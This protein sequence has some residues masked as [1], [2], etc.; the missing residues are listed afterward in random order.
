MKSKEA[1]NGHIQLI[2]GVFAFLDTALTDDKIEEA[3][4]IDPED[5]S[6]RYWLLSPRR[7]IADLINETFRLQWKRCPL[8]KELAEYRLYYRDDMA[9][10]LAVAYSMKLRGEDPEVALNADYDVK[11]VILSWQDLNEL[12][13]DYEGVWREFR[14]LQEEGD[15]VVYYN[16][17]NDT[18]YY[19]VRG[20]RIVWKCE[21]MQFCNRSG[22]GKYR[23]AVAEFNRR[24]GARGFLNDEFV[25]PDPDWVNP[26]EPDPEP[27][28]P[29]L[30]KA[31]GDENGRVEDYF[32]ES[33]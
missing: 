29:W 25:W 22:L 32:E 31:F 20:T 27:R 11:D 7:Q 8:R 18:G 17:H 12:K 15:R 14:R 9:D 26:G 30:L 10:A 33:D 24:G 19:L 6:N 3:K 2:E 1:D 23:A 5:E 13:L 21:A 28:K 16:A 4:T